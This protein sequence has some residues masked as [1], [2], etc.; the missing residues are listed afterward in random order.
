MS[1]AD[2]IAT[3]I[4]SSRIL[5]DNKGNTVKAV[6]GGRTY[7]PQDEDWDSES[8]DEIPPLI[9]SSSSDSDSDPDDY[10]ESDDEPEDT[11]LPDADESTKVHP[12]S[13]NISY[14][15]EE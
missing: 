14:D 5:E 9:E 2:T 12:T 7:D 13:S 3:D 15:T 6:I 4:P 10:S 1:Y 8:D 11:D